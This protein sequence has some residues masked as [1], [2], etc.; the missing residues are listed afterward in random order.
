MTAREPEVDVSAA[1]GAPMGTQIR[2]ARTAQ[3]ITLREL[4]RR[5]NVSPSFVSQLERNKVNASVGTLYNLVNALGMSLDELMTTAADAAPGEET[6]AAPAPAVVSPPVPSEHTPASALDQFPALDWDPEAERWPRIEHP[7]QRSGARARIR[8]PGVVWERLTRG[9]DPF[10]DFLHVEYA[11]GSASC[12][13]D[14]MMRHGG[15]EYG[16]ILSGRLD[17]QVGFDTHVL[18]PGDAI[19]FDSMTPHRLSNPFDESCQAIWFVVA[20]RSD[21]RS[22]DMVDPSPS[23]THLPSI[24]P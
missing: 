5:I 3:G 9:A 24:H 19:T 14:D 23:V 10:V 1:G 16:Y 15:H 2:K 21:D 13:E 18:E 11:P 8:F 7:V 17:V 12:P 22:A 20:R 4:A 6:P